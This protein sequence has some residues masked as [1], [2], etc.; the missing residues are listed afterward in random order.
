MK[1]N[2]R[3]KEDD[4]CPICLDKINNGK[5]LDYCKYSCGLTLHKKCFEMWEKRNKG[6]CVF[7]RANWYPDKKKKNYL[8]VNLINNQYTNSNMI[9]NS[10]VNDII[11]E[12]NDEEEN[13]DFLYKKRDRSKE[14][15]D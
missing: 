14:S 8:Y 3:I 1:V 5:E 7:C 9:N 15:D 12:K 10:F 4:I 13:S 6:I 2:Q 11:L